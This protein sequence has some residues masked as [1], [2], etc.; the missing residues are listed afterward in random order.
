MGQLTNQYVSQSYQGLLNLSNP[1]TG[2]TNTLQYVTDGLGGN[3]ALQISATEV[4]VTGSFYIN[5]VPI[6]N[7]TS[8]TS[9][10]SGPLPCACSMRRS[11]FN[12]SYDFLT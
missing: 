4:N 12:L 8:G 7:G 11:S 10:T 5:G 3:T 1:F 6:T 2:V 9:G